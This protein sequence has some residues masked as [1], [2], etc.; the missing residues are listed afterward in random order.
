MSLT[1]GTVGDFWYR[2]WSLGTR[3]SRRER[4]VVVSLV[5]THL[6]GPSEVGTDLGWVRRTTGDLVRSPFSW[7]L[8]HPT[9]RQADPYGS[10]QL[11]IST[12]HHVK[13][14]HLEYID[15][16]VPSEFLWTPW[17]LLPTLSQTPFSLSPDK[18]DYGPLTFIYFQIDNRKINHSFTVGV[19][20]TQ[21]RRYC[22]TVLGTQRRTPNQ[23]HWRFIDVHTPWQTDGNRGTVWRQRTF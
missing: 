3:S 6:Q 9:S 4:K 16:L 21:F 10:G 12:P 22:F 7:F 18:T 8:L 11:S 13:L 2:P 17:P 23:R 1:S 19:L 14:C 5:P 15:K 20:P